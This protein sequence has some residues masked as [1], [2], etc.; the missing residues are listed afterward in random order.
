MSVVLVT[1][2]AGY[3][4]SHTAKA[5]KAAGYTPLTV[6][7]LSRGYEWAVKWGPI[8]KADLQDRAAL[9]AIFEKHRP[10]AVV[11]FA[12]Y[13]YVGE[14]VGDPYLYYR[15]NVNGT[16]SL[17]EAMRAADCDKIVFSSTC[18]TYGLP[19]TL[20]I[21]EETPQTP[22]NPYGA[23]KLMIERVLSDA[24]TA[25]GLKSVALRYFN[26]AGSD[27]D[28][29]IGE[30]HDPETHLIPLALQAAAGTGPG[31]KV[32]GD[33][34]DTPDGS[35]IRDYVHVSDLADAH[36]KA[37]EWL[38]AGRE[39]RRFNLGNGRGF[40]VFEVIRAVEAVT[41]RKVPHEIAPRR[42]G[43]PTVLIANARRAIDELG[44]APRYTAL[45][46][47]IEHAWRWTSRQVSEKASP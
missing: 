5:L 19:D 44:W 25:Y 35:C 4:G 23:S 28:G 15:N 9:A 16:L 20:P 33:D 42:P 22:V 29:E 7:N 26:A 31:L 8:E 13:A 39:S 36:V 11:H 37:L 21:T 24:D 18:A 47:Q 10:A 3:I 17:L 46:T 45:E 41:G 2:G 40:S 38:A 30:A 34:Y 32:F 27:P 6:D 1:G 43:D 12:A 14:S